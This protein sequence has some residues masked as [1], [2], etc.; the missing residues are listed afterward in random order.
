MTHD[1]Y[2][3]ID[4]GGTK[5]AVGLASDGGG[6]LRKA[7]IP[8]SQDP[9]EALE[10][11]KAGILGLMGPAVLPTDSRRGGGKGGAAGSPDGEETQAA[12][13]PAGKPRLVR[14]GIGSPGPVDAS[15]GVVLGTPNLPRWRGVRLKDFLGKAFGCEVVVENDADSA[16]L[17]EYCRGAGTG[18]RHMVYLGLGTGVG[19]GA[20]KEGRIV[21]GARGTHPELG[22][23]TI[24]PD[25]PLC[26]CGNRG[27]L[28]SYVSGSGIRRLTGQNPQD[29]RDPSFWQDTG[30]LLGVGLANVATM[31][32]PDRIVLG[33]GLLGVGDVLIE[34]ARSYID[35]VA[36]LVPRPEVVAA[37]LGQDAGLVGAVL[38]ALGGEEA[39]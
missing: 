22:H 12:V 35:G 15:G 13:A 9:V 3:G 27:C 30:R 33:G 4:I 21:R 39:S 16:A 17:A 28:E 38:L 6:I 5:T 2:C 25:G 23:Q 10:D 7:V 24:N 19:S 26:G 1:L 29:I 14:I 37:G 34:S 18:V 11:M 8:T 36:L 31:L 20:I 32:V